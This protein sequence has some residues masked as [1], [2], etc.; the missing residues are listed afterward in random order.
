MTSTSTLARHSTDDGA[1]LILSRRDDVY[2]LRVDG[3]ELMTSRA[4]RSE[5]ELARLAC[6]MLAG[7]ERPRVLVAGLGFGFTLRA[8]LDRL[9]TDAS[10]AV[11]EVFDCLLSW[12]R[13]LLAHLAGRPL[14]DPR[15]RAHHADVTDYLATALAFDAILL[16]VDNGPEAFTLRSNQQLYEPS[17][18]ALLRDRLKPQGVLAVWSATASEDFERRVVG[19]GFEVETATVAA[20]PGRKGPRHHL[21]PGEKAVAQTPTGLQRRQVSLVSSDLPARPIGRASH[22]H[23][24]VR[25]H[26]HGSSCTR[27]DSPDQGT[28]GETQRRKA[29]GLHLPR[30]LRRSSRPP[31]CRMALTEEDHHGRRTDLLRPTRLRGR[32][33]GEE[34]QVG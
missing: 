5:E 21:F 34:D 33:S 11:C 1:S 29:T 31:G 3:L 30:I 27:C 19:A 24:A 9:P 28:P 4:H 15:V 6:E 20:R 26:H 25:C 8:A 2:T 22:A 10:V 13:D 16:D 17:G 12:N 18:L 32:Q 14:D 7:H 23:P